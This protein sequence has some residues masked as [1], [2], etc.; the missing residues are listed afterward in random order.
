[1]H[2]GDIWHLLPYCTKGIKDFS[3]FILLN[4]QSQQLFPHVEL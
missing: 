2:F 3:G 1:M 4:N